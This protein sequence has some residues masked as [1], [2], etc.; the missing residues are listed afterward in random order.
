M[1]QRI[2]ILTIGTALFLLL[3]GRIWLQAQTHL[4]SQVGIKFIGLT[5]NSAGLLGSSDKVLAVFSVTNNVG[6]PIEA[7]FFYY[8]ETSGYWSSYAPLG[9]GGQVAPRGCGTILT[10]IPTNGVPWRVIVPYSRA[11]LPGQ[12]AG[13]VF[14]AMESALKRPRFGFNRYGKGAPTSDWVKP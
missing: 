3:A 6:S 1:L 4:G 5:N 2:V 9:A 8:I 13:G 11:T 10:R 12:I 7:A 14:D